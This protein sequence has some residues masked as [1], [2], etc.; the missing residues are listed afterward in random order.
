MAAGRLIALHITLVML[1][2][3]L[4]RFYAFCGIVRT[5]TL[6]W[7]LLQCHMFRGLSRLSQSVTTRYKAPRKCYNYV[8]RPKLIVT[9]PYAQPTLHTSN[10]SSHRRRKDV[11]RRS[12]FEKT[13][14]GLTSPGQILKFPGR[15]GVRS[16]R[17][18]M[19]THR[20]LSCQ[21]A[22]EIDG[23]RTS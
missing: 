9:Q 12:T 5:L 14:T 8:A 3:S 13:Y 11:L 7:C 18:A 4:L 2:Q 15:P 6:F 21:E 19:L 16:P 10:E 20:D 23:A 22:C 1:S 17:S